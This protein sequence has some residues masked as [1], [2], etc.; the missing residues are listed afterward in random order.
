MTT[1]AEGIDKIRRLFVEKTRSRF[2]SFVYAY[3]PARPYVWGRPTHR[4]VETL[5]N[6][7]D[8][9]NQGL[10]SYVMIN[11]PPRTGKSDLCSRR[12]A[13]W[14][15]IDHPDDEI[16]L[17]CY[18]QDLAND[19]SRDAR[20]C[21]AEIAPSYGYS[22]AGDRDRISSWGIQDHKGGM[23]AVGL[24][25]SITGRGSSVLLIDDYLKNRRDAE[26]ELI[27][28]RGWDSFRNDLMTRLAPVHIVIIL[29][30]RWHEDD[31][32]GR[33]IKS[34]GAVENF[35]QFDIVRMPAQDEDTGE[36][37]FPE[38]FPDSWYETQKAS[39]GSYGW[40]CLYQNAPTAR[41]GNLF[42]VDN[43]KIV[44]KLPDNLRYTR[45]WDL[46]S[47]EKQRIKDDPDYTVGAKTSFDP[48]NRIVYLKDIVR[49]QAEA[50]ERDRLIKSTAIKD[51]PGVHQR[52]EQ[53]AG[54]KDTVTR[55]S[56][57]LKGISIVESYKP[58]GDKVTRADPLEPI[59]DCGNFIIERAPWNDSFISWMRGFP[60]AAHD[61]DVDG[62]VISL[63]EALH[64]ISG[65]VVL[66]RGN[67]GF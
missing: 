38:R 9:Y 29:A 30:T 45:G 8:R 58:I 36:Y 63:G 32:G 24:G 46:A 64:G 55:M 4:M 54:Y 16:I 5:Q 41:H 53:V 20:K 10:C 13:P 31:I 25:A 33:I 15:L 42:N 65:G 37:L 47:S 66:P 57:E 7:V 43:I 51:G 35:P 50:P 14:F 59:I 49:C 23:N 12:F 6:A 26:S 28:D 62:V 19:M 3:P 44:D 34:M 18:G 27:R 52:I 60:S 21:M 1:K 48:D 11:V 22:M 40:Q 61:D 2:K 56:D 67:F 39:V 17:S